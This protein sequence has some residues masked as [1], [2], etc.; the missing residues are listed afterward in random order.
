MGYYASEKTPVPTNA[1]IGIQSFVGMLNVIS[2]GV[3]LFKKSPKK[4][5]NIFLI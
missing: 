2:W 1:G 3:N 4:L 5:C